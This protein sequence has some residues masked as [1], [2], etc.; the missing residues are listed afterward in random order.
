MAPGILPAAMS[1]LT[2]SSIATSFSTD[3]FAPGRG[4]KSAATDGSGVRS[5]AA[6]SSASGFAGWQV[7]WIVTLLHCC[8]P[9]QMAS[10]IWI[11]QL[12][13]LGG[14]L[15]QQVDE[16]PDLGRE[17]VAVRIDRIHR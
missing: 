15:R 9:I 1:A 17:M 3:K 13:L 6:T 4:P 11:D 12:L 2:K 8:A 5:R 16:G 14:M 7:I 10:R